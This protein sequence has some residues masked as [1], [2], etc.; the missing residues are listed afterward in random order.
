MVLDDDVQL[1]DRARDRAPGEPAA[2]LRG[3][4]V[5]EGDDLGPRAVAVVHLPGDRGGSTTGADDDDPPSAT[6]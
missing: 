5:D 2:D 4:V 1:G 6:L 3:V